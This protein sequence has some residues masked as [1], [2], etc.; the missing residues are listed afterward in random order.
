MT[1]QLKV[2]N[3]IPKYLDT[4]T[5]YHTYPKIIAGPF[6]YLLMVLKNCWSGKQCKPDQV[7]FYAVSGPQSDAVLCR[8]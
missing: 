3:S 8:V 4:F 2:L 7:L 5:P 1:Q 6:Y